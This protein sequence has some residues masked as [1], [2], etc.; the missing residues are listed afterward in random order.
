MKSRRGEVAV[1]VAQAQGLASN[2]LG[3]FEAFCFDAVVDDA[4][5]LVH[6][7][8]EWRRLNVGGA[9][10]GDQRGT[11]QDLSL[12][13]R[14]ELSGPLLANDVAVVA[15]YGGFGASQQELSE[16]CERIG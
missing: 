6:V 1:L 13:R 5:F 15:D 3:F 11:F 8:Q 16:F 7:A 10:S 14:V 4:A 9:G 12:K 2:L